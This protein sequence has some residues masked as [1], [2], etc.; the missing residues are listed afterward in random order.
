MSKNI[1]SQSLVD[2]NIKNN[3]PINEKE[4]QNKTNNG[5]IY[6]YNLENLMYVGDKGE[7]IKTFSLN[8]SNVNTYSNYNEN[9][10]KSSPIRGGIINLSEKAI[11]NMNDISFKDKND[12][13][14]SK[15]NNNEILNSNL[16]NNIMSFQTQT[17]YPCSQVNSLSINGNKTINKD[18]NLNQKKTMLKSGNKIQTSITKTNNYSKS[19]PVS[20]SIKSKTTK[21]NY[22]F[23]ISNNAVNIINNNKDKN[24]KSNINNDINYSNYNDDKNLN[25]NSIQQSI[26]INLNKDEYNLKSNPQQPIKSEFQKSFDAFLLEPHSTDNKY[27]FINNS[28]GNYQSK[29]V[30]INSIKDLKEQFQKFLN[31][32]GKN[33][34]KSPYIIPY[35]E[36]LKIISNN[37]ENSNDL[38]FELKSFLEKSKKYQYNSLIK[39]EK[40]KSLMILSS[41]RKNKEYNDFSDN[42]PMSLLDN[43]SILYMVTRWIKYSFPSVEYT[44]SYP[45]NNEEFKFEKESEINDDESE[46][47]KL[48]NKN[49]KALEEIERVKKDL[50]NEFSKKDQESKKLKSVNQKLKNRKNSNE[51]KKKYQEKIK[52]K[53]IS[54]Q[55]TEKDYAY[56]PEV[57]RKINEWE[58]RP[59]VSSGSNFSNYNNSFGN[60]KMNV[61]NDSFKQQK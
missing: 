1:I 4:K 25:Q 34:N 14:N 17:I 31:N 40:E 3:N 60:Q 27:V 35:N 37:I 32:L 48:I 6:T 33:R 47:Q 16:N 11:Q 51:K 54:S 13:N 45:S 2:K 59:F 19:N 58:N 29:I 12:L 49:N 39:T 5:N 9:N 10:R 7:V 55:I 28:D 23:S 30:N 38:F 43:K 46:N 8:T 26:N 21:T 24:S 44:F 50:L 52:D 42:T 36:F 57:Q 15:N 53:N 22:P 18:I 61:N 56:K 20:F 41:I